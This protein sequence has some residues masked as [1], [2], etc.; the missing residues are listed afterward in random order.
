MNTAC[1][2]IALA[3]LGQE[4]APTRPMADNRNTPAE[5]LDAMRAAARSYEVTREANPLGAASTKVEVLTDPVFRS[6]KQDGN[7]FDA[8]VF[9][10]AD[11]TGRPEAA[12]EMFLVGEGGVTHGKWIHEF[13]SLSA[14][15]LVAS[16]DG[17]PRWFPG[18]PG[19]KLLPVPDAPRPASTPVQRLVQMRELASQFQADDDYGGKGNWTVLRMLTRPIARFG[20]P[21]AGVEDGALFAFVEKTDPEAFLFLEARPGANG[22]EWQYA[23]AP[24]GCWAVRVKH[25]GH[26]VWEVP[27][28]SP[29]D[30]AKPLYSEQFWP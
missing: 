26:T 19:I 30:P 3:L 7:F 20:K 16:H 17:K 8:G 27:W 12:M 29:G 25:K 5:R 18:E 13:T 4:A 9:L 21:G 24:M 10:W 23:L 15:R 6:G 28:R 11:A 14:A 2:W 1:L 22:L